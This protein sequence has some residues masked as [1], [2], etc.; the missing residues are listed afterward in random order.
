MMPAYIIAI[1]IFL[2][3]ALFLGL[4]VNQV[5]RLLRKVIFLRTDR[6]LELVF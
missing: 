2:Q 6:R 3:V 5:G 4:T 1:G